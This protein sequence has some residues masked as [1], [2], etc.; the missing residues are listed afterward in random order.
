MQGTGFDP[1]SINMYALPT[2][3]TDPSLRSV[4]ALSLWSVFQHSRAPRPDDLSSF[5]LCLPVGEMCRRWAAGLEG[6]TAAPWGF[7]GVG[8]RTELL[9]CCLGRDLRLIEVTETICKR[10]LDYS[11]HKERTGS[12]RF[13]K[14]G[15]VLVP[16][17][18]WGRALMNLSVSA[19]VCG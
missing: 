15:F 17:S 2:P 10:L 18:L 9:C 7:R 1:E 14:V 6:R 8:R 19:G 3:Y 16:H 5:Q 4:K 11:L 12:N 13:A